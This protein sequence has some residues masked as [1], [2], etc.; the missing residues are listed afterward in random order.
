MIYAWLEN[1]ILCI[2]KNK[3]YANYN[4]KIFDCD[5]DDIIYDGINIRIKTEEEKEKDRILQ[6]AE[7]AK[8]QL[9]ETDKDVVRVIEDIIDVLVAKKVVDY[10]DLPQ[11]VQEKLAERKTLREKLK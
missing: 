10:K 9:I 2:T 4:A 3:Q 11:S 1:N 6:E 7:E 5:Y 8:Q